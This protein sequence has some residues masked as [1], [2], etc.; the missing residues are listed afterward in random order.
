MSSVMWVC[1]TQSA[2]L[3]RLLRSRSRDSAC[4][5]RRASPGGRGAAPASPTSASPAPRRGRDEHR[6]GQSA[7]GAVRSMPASPDAC[8]AAPIHPSRS[9]QARRIA[10]KDRPT[11]MMR[12]WCC[13]CMRC[14]ESRSCVSRGTMNSLAEDLRRPGGGDAA[15]QPAQCRL[16]P[17]G[18]LLGDGVLA[19]A[20]DRA[21]DYFWRARGR[22][23]PAGQGGP[24]RA[25]PAD[26]PSHRNAEWVARETETGRRFEVPGAEEG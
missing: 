23:L 9:R 4:P 19:S 16:S 22:D 11:T 6:G 7:P 3:W 2:R 17:S 1:D 21:R 20:R 8:R 10:G 5:R 15:D 25:L 18:Q 26:C 24:H 14:D 12:S 13:A